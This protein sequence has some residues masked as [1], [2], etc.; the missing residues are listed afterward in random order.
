VTTVAELLREARARGLDRLDAQLLLAHHLGRA[1]AWL[2][3][4][5]DAAVADGRSADIRRDIA[6]RAR[7]MPLAYLV[8]ER[9]FHG[10]MLR[11]TTDVLVP[12]PDTEVLVDWALEL[13]A[14]NLG[15]VSVP[16]VADLGTGSGAIALA[17]KHRCPRA[18]VLG[19]D[20]SQRALAVARDNARRLGL[21]VE[22]RTGNWLAG[23][24]SRRFHLL[25][26]NPP[27]I[28][29]N[30]PHLAALHA[31]PAQALTPGVDGLC[32]LRAIIG[33]APRHLHA[34]GWLL[35]EHG[36]TQG[37]AVEAALRTAGFER[38]T[39]RPDLAGRPRCTGGCWRPTVPVASG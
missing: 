26:S 4:H 11:V 33:Q 17:V 15:A 1:R 20:A 29:G 37:S 19:L 12:R 23:L 3:A 34:G 21:E 38:I 32:D 25:L 30:D 31:E 8:G 27:Y 2:I 35:L 14:G 39:T 5:E 10:L 24:E 28:D 18:S 16:A 9:E 7:G 6:E 13:L 36:H 22:A